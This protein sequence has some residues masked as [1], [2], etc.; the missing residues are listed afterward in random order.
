MENQTYKDMTALEFLK[1]AKRMCRS[2]ENCS[3]CVMDDEYSKE[4]KLIILGDSVKEFEKAIENVYNWSK[5]HPARTM[6]DVL[7]ETFPDAKRRKEDGTPSVCPQAV[8]KHFVCHG[9]CR[10]CIKEFW[11]SEVPE[12]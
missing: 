8:V 4:C 3:N 1:Q 5:E 12:K 10:K 11:N 7:F 6:A 9:G 2:R